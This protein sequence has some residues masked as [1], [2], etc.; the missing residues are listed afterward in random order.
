MRCAPNSGGAGEHRGGLGVE[1]TYRCLQKC[2]ANINL[3]RTT[4]SAVG[5]AWRHARRDQ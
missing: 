3:D 4:R 2:K 1:L 5:P